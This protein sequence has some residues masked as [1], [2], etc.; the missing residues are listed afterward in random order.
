[1]LKKLEIIGVDNY[2]YT[3]KDEQN[4]TYQIQFEFYDLETMPNI[5]DYITMPKEL[6]DEKLVS[7]KIFEYTFSKIKIGSVV[8]INE[9]G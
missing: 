7:Q 2:L 1:M 3:L 4:K 6:L 8:E 9:K 5:G